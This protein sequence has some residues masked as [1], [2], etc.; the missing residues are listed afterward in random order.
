MSFNIIRKTCILTDPVLD[1]QVAEIVNAVNALTAAKIGAEELGT[2][3]AVHAEHMAEFD[4]EGIEHANRAALDV[5][6]GVNTGDQDLAPYELAGVA[7]AL[8][9]SHIAAFVHGDIAHSNR[10]ALNLVSGTNTGDQDLTALSAASSASASHIA[11]TAAHGATGGVV[12]TTNTQTLSNKKFGGVTN[13][14]EFEADGSLV[15]KAGATVFKDENF[16]GA[17]TAIGPNAPALVNWSTTSVLIPSFPHNLTKELNMLKEYDHAGKVGADITVHAHIFPSNT[18]IGTAK[19]FCEYI[20]KNDGNPAVTG[21]LNAS[22]TT[23]GVAWDELRLNIGTISSA[24]LTQGTQIGMRLYR[25]STDT[26]TYA[27]PVAVSTWGYHY[28]LDMV[29]SRE[30]TTK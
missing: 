27:H 9:A 20:L 16:G 10:A 17:V 1:Y 5:V 26:G 6:A 30:I 23:G 12:G 28:E 3:D 13:Y 2:A 14:S 8:D 7:A 29:G 25:L 15:F 19:F 11:A 22:V 24:M 4:H 21:T 18:V